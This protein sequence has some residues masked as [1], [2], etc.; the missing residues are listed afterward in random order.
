MLKLIVPYLIHRKK[1]RV[2]NQ[3][4]A[5]CHLKMLPH[6]PAGKCSIQERPRI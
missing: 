6:A 5:D 3:Q 4:N 2:N 1:E